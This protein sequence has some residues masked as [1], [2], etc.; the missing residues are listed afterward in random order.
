[1]NKPKGSLA[2]E[3]FNGSWIHM[4]NQMLVL[5]Y[6]RWCYLVFFG[7]IVRANLVFYSALVVVCKTSVGEKGKSTALLLRKQP[8]VN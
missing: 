1:M 3:I 7:S 2:K 6:L 5:F 8:A 4:F